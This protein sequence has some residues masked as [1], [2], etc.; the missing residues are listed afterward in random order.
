MAEKDWP[1]CSQCADG[2]LIPL[3]DFGP[4]GSDVMY[5]AWAC[6]DPNCGFMLR[7][8]KGQISL[9]VVCPQGER[10]TPER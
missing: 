3:S 10:T 7:I 5:K 1:A 8:D 4:N 6:T 2:V 9:S